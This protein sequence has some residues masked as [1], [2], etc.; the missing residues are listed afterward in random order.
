MKTCNLYGESLDWIN[1]ELLGDGCITMRSSIAAAFSYSSKYLEYI[2]YVSDTLWY[3]GIVRTG[4]IREHYHEKF[5]K[6]SY[7]YMSRS[8]YEL[9]LLHELWYPSGIKEVPRS[10]ELTSL[11][12]RQWYIGDG[13][14][15]H[16][17][18][19]TP[20][21]TLFTCA[22]K[23]STVYWLVRQLALIGIQATRDNTRNSV[24]ISL[25]STKDFLTYIGECPV[26]CYR[27]KWNLQEGRR[28]YDNTSKVRGELD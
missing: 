3:F 10:I 19:H 6:W 14:L 22:F 16:R 24:S 2:K 27:Y 5:N 1:G 15:Y 26:E 11:T 9:R 13:T 21:I 28:P 17:K 8:Y 23:D 4:R 20:H 12:C 18:G 7:H 25:Y